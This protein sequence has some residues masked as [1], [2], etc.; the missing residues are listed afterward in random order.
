[1]ISPEPGGRVNIAAIENY[2]FVLAIA[3]YAYF[4]LCLY[5]LARKTETDNAWWAFVPLLNLVLL[6]EIADRPVWWFFLCFVPILNLLIAGLVWT[7]VAEVRCKPSWVGWLMLL[8]GLNLF[9]LGYLA[10]SA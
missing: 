5:V 4:S 6:L 9:V 10:F 3:V 8:P 2:G 7:G 1:L